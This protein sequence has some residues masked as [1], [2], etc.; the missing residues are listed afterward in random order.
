MT[1]NNQTYAISLLTDTEILRRI[2]WPYSLRLD[3]HSEIGRA[4]V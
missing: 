4:H 2:E 1:T 3:P